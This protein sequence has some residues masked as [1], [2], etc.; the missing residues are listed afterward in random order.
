[1]EQGLPLKDIHLPPEP[2]LWPLAPGWWLLLAALVL[3]IIGAILAARYLGPR[4]RERRRRQLRSKLWAEQVDSL[5]EPGL[6]LQAA[7]DLVRRIALKDSPSTARLQGETWLRLLADSLIESTEL[8][9]TLIALTSL[10]YQK[11]P[12]APQAETLLALLKTR[13]LRGFR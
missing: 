3:L 7:L 11:N 9:N 4:L 6:R 5:A 1:M 12:P 2:A 10:P 13:A 8:E